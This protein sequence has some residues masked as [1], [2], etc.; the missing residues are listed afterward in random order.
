LTWWYENGQKW[1][2]GTYKDGELIDE[3]SFNEDND[4]FNGP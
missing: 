1:E 3:K 2:E 4:G